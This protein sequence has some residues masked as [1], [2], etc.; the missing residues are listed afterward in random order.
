MLK[1]GEIITCAPGSV[2]SLNVRNWEHIYK[3]PFL[4]T[5]IFFFTVFFH[6]VRRQNIF[7]QPGPAVKCGSDDDTDIYYFSP[8]V[9][10]T[11]PDRQTV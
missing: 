5:L 3:L 2:I 7:M 6:L 1:T 8:H 4:C 9:S 10:R 11:M